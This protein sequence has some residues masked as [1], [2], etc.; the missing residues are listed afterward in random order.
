MLRRGWR[1]KIREAAENRE[2]EMKAR[3]HKEKE[4]NAKS[5]SARRAKTSVGAVLKRAAT[6]IGRH[7][8]D[9]SK[10]EE[11][12]ENEWYTDSSEL[13]SMDVDTLARYV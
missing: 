5:Q 11:R 10:Y 4:T 9:V 7:N 1:Q 13:R 6:A 8:I 2:T 12:L 3:A